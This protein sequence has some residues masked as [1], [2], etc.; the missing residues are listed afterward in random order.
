MYVAVKGGE[1]AIENA[2]RLLAHERR[3]DRDVPE[4]SLA[5]ISEQLSLGV[6]RVMAEGSLYDR[7]LA[8]LAIKQAG[9]DMIEA[10][11]LVRAFRATLPRLGATE[12]V[13]T[14]RVQGPPPVFLDFKDYSRSQI[15][16]PTFDYTHRLLDPHLAEA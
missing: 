8:A 1:R 11:F 5:Q 7:E 13:E 10:I 4:L 6:D 3:G 2:H 15:L 12:T 14:R 16:G 9:G